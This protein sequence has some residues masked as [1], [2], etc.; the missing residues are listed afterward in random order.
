MKI[1]A[2]LKSVQGFGIRV[3]LKAY[4]R[5]VQLQWEITSRNFTHGSVGRRRNKSSLQKGL[6]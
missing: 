3:G 4:Q 5:L 6:L 2:A 1:S